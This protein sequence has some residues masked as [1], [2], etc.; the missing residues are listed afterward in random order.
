[1]VR[2]P[3][4]WFL[5]ACFVVSAG[6]AADSPPASSAKVDFARDVEPIFHRNCYACHGPSMQ[7]NGLRL[8][9]R[10][11]AF[12]GGHSGKAIVPSDS[13]A[14]LLMRRV[15]SADAKLNMPPGDVRLSDDEIGVLRAWIDQGAE[16]PEKA[17]PVETKPSDAAKHWSFQ[18][19]RRPE[20]PEVSQRTWVRNPIDRFVLAKLEAEGIR[21]SVEAGK[22]TLLR[23][24]HFDLTGLPP[25]PGEIGEFLWDNAPGAYERLVDRLLDSPHYGEKWARSWLD[26]ARYADSDGFEKRP[27]PAPFLALAALGDRGLEPRHAVRPVHGGADRR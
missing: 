8:D 17:E 21:P 23:R 2:C 18:P 6:S 19:V 24:L 27:R 3:V 26:L 5:L 15:A 4:R 16:W 20:P 9:Q 7:M 25:G 1:M 11:A 12:E 22:V 13:E 10:A 14:S